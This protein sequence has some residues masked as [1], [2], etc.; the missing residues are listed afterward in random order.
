M[1]YNIGRASRTN[2]GRVSF[3]NTSMKAV[4]VERIQKTNLRAAI[5]LLVHAGGKW[6]SDNVPRLSAA[7]SFYAALSLAPFLIIATVVAVYFVG[8][9]A[10]NR[11]TILGQV[12]ITFGVQAA[13]LLEQ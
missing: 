12:R 3:S 5:D 11:M 9:D 1:F 4:K 2:G 10:S 6:S 13:D 7:V 8:D